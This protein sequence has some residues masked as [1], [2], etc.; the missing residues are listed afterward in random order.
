M[1]REH[2]QETE[3]LQDAGWGNKRRPMSRG[4]IPL[5][6]ISMPPGRQAL[7]LRSPKL[8]GVG[9][10]FIPEGMDSPDGHVNHCWVVCTAGTRYV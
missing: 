1:A 9:M 2:Q 7:M 3:E 10:C 8:G 5:A 4:I 6:M